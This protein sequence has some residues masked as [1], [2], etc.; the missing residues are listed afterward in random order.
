[1]FN[2][3]LNAGQNILIYESILDPW[4][5]SWIN[6]Q[7][8]R[9]LLPQCG[10]DYFN[11]Q[12]NR[13]FHWTILMQLQACRKKLFGWNFAHRRAAAPGRPARNQKK[14]T[15]WKK[16]SSLTGELLSWWWVCGSC[17][18]PSFFYLFTHQW[19]TKSLSFVQCMSAGHAIFRH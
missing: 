18:L 17:F 15:W 8:Y 9:F 1:M 11:L 16:P 12:E 2:T 5:F 7:C 14:E 3:A 10:I 4:N 6:F 13:N 19:K